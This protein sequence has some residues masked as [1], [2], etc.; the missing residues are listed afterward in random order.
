MPNRGSRSFVAVDLSRIESNVRAIVRRLGEA[1]LWVVVK[2]NGYGIGLECFA[3]AAANAGCYGFVCAEVDEGERLRE[4]GLRH[5]IAC[6]IFPTDD[7]L[8]CAAELSLDLSIGSSLQLERLAAQSLKKPLR[9][10]VEVDTGMGRGGFM[11]AEITD[12]VA[13]VQ[14]LSG[15]VLTGFWSHLACSD[16]PVRSARQRDAFVAACDGAGVS[17]PRY[18]IGTEGLALGPDFFL[19]GARI[20]LGCLG[21]VPR[22]TRTDLDLR[23]AIRW[24]TRLTAVFE[25][26]CGTTIGYG[27]QTQLQRASRL[28]LIPV[29]ISDGYPQLSRGVVGLGGTLAPIVGGVGMT[30]MV[31]DLTDVGHVPEGHVVHLLGCVGPDVDDLL[32]LSTPQVVP[33]SFLCGRTGTVALVHASLKDDQDFSAER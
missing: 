12:V 26:P 5:P 15:V 27:A 33:N 24:T 21:L 17:A 13:R 20:G 6:L 23:L 14:R 25:R 7:A 22:S 3:A 10:L 16:D 1:A 32:R 19:N 29:G 2:G 11:P 18:L 30:S 9:V 8:E 4:A 31:V 28:G